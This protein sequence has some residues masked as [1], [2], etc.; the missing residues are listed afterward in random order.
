M[1]KD[2]TPVSSKYCKEVDC[3]FRSG[4]NCTQDTCIR[5]GGDK[6]AVYW[7]EHGVLEGGQ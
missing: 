2:R 7:V 6:W 4:N 5:E 3:E 1:A